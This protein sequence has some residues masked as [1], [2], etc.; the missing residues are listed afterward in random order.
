LE[1]QNLSLF[2]RI[3]Y[4]VLLWIFDRQGWHVVNANPSLRKCII[5]AA[6]HTSNWDFV[7]VMGARARLG[8]PLSYVGKK[9][10]FR[11]PLG[12]VM[13]ELGGFP[14]DRSTSKNY[15]QTIIDEFEK[16][17]EFM[18]IIAPE[19]KRGAVTRWKTGFYHMAMGA[20]VPLVLGVC[21]YARKEVGLHRAIMPTG[22]YARDVSQIM[23]F[24]KQAVPR[25]PSQGSVD[26]GSI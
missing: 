21:D 25:H 18:L 9:Q 6:P 10:M 4:H 1:K 26:F 2:T 13:R 5:I 3:V 11:W 23:D 8:L 16:R 19:G 12:R 7:Y 24:Y 17:D 14:V 15:V 20:G 22:D